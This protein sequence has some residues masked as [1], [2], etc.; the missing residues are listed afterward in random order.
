MTLR[1]STWPPEGRFSGHERLPASLR[2]M[3]M[4]NRDHSDPRTPRDIRRTLRR[5]QS[6]VPRSSRANGLRSK[7]TSQ[8]SPHEAKSRGSPGKNGSARKLRARHGARS[9][10]LDSLGA[11]LGL[12]TFG[13]TH[14]R[15]DPSPRSPT[16]SISHHAVAGASV[17]THFL[18]SCRGCL[19]PGSLTRSLQPESCDSHGRFPDSFPRISRLGNTPL[20]LREVKILYVCCYEV[21]CDLKSPNA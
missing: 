4:T 16:N 21:L 15:L 19:P 20:R 18:P 7:T 5:P 1:N 8:Q 12:G 13:T 6:Q 11:D 10:S 3:F 9:G 14:E 17:R 2:G